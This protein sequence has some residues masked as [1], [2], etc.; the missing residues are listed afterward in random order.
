MAFPWL[1]TNLN[2]DTVILQEW[3]ALTILENI[4]SFK[5]IILIS[6]SAFLF[7]ISLSNSVSVINLYLFGIIAWKKEL[8]SSYICLT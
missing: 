6:S 3:S 5:T 1:C 4:L 8:S 7:S 2:A